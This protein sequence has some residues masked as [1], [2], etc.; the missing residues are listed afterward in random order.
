[1][2]NVLT[3]AARFDTWLLIRL[4]PRGVVFPFLSFP[5]LS[6]PFLFCSVLFLSCSTCSCA[7]LVQALTKVLYDMMH[8]LAYTT[9]AQMPQM[10]CSDIGLPKTDMH[11]LRNLS[12]SVIRKCLT[13]QPERLAFGAQTLPLCTHWLVTMASSGM[14]SY[15]EGQD[16]M[17]GHKGLSHL[18]L[19]YSDVVGKRLLHSRQHSCSY[20]RQCNVLQRC[21]AECIG[22]CGGS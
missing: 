13:T 21:P 4:T 5:F 22:S 2:F 17:A 14:K 20:P 7:M 8:Q 10:P 1:V 11:M 15:A 19:S 6:F 12:M 18:A 16:V 3:W 9:P